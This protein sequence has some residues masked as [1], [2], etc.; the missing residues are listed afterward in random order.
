MVARASEYDVVI[1]SYDL[2]RRDWELYGDITFDYAVAD[3]AQFIKNPETKTP[4]P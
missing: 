3:E 2:I 1:T 4:L